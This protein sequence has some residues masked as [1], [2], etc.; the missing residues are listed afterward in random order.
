MKGFYYIE[1][2]VN[3]FNSSQTAFFDTL[4]DAKEAMKYCGD[5]YRPMGTGKIYFQPT[6][7]EV[8]TLTTTPYGKKELVE[9]KRIK[10]SGRKFICRGAGLD[11]NGEVIFSDKEW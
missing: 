3:E 8:I 11:E 6:E 4:E 9:Y 5:W 7:F 10:Q 1:N 2:S